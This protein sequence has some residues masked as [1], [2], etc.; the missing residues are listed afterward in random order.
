MGIDSV[1]ILADTDR[2]M[3]AATLTPSATGND[4]ETLQERIAGLVYERQELR[5]AHADR[6]RLE[7]NRLEIADLQQRLSR[8]LIARH[9]PAPQPAF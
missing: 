6:E 2:A 4:V 1:T 8:A 5:A 3:T 9:T 7:Q